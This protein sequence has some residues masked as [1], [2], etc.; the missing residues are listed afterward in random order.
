MIG[1]NITKSKSKPGKYLFILSILGL[2]L[3]IALPY[4]PFADN[5]GLSP[6]PL[7]NLGIMISIVAAYIITADLLKVWFFKKYRNG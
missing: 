2:A 7:L 5:V 3:T 6:L 1:N 4:S